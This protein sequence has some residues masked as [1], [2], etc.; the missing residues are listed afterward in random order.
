MLTDTVQFLSPCIG[1][2]I[3]QSADISWRWTEW[4]AVLMGAVSLVAIVLLAR[5]TYAP[6][7]LSWRARHLRDLTG[8]ERY[9]SKLEIQL[10]PLSTRLR[11]SLYRPFDMFRREITVGLFTAYLTVLY[12]EYEDHMKRALPRN[13]HGKEKVSKNSL[14][15]SRDSVVSFSF[16]TAYPII[17]GDIYRFSQGSVGLCFLSLDV[18]IL[19]A[20]AIGVPLHQKYI[21]DLAKAREAGQQGLPPESRLWFVMLSAPGKSPK[22]PCNQLVTLK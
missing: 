19:V 14:I 1:S 18:G 6:L 3:G 21:R 2:F 5:E 22:D 16:L 4:I 11:K 12:G 7:I 9:R 20:G 15:S 8:D 17:Y 13:R 10:E